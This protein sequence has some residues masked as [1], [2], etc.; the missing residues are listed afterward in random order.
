MQNDGAF[1]VRLVETPVEEITAA[2]VILGALG[3][4]GLMSVA[5]A[6]LGLGLGWVLIVRS[7]RHGLDRE[8][9]PSV[10]PFNPSTPL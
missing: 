6:L 3:I 8:H 5:A 10:H 4:A 9:P 7:R 2:D 1:I